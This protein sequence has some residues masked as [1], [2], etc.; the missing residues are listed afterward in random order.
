MI[1]YKKLLNY[2]MLMKSAHDLSKTDE[3]LSKI[4]WDRIYTMLRDKYLN[5]EEYEFILFKEIEY[6]VVQHGDKALREI[7]DDIFKI[8]GIYKEPSYVV[9]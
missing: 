3:I 5:D 8:M 1:E 7:I 4:C 9:D 2:V 6:K